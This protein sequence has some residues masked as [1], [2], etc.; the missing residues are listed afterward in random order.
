[1]SPLGIAVDGTGNLFVSDSINNRV[2]KITASN[3]VIT[4]V[5][6]TGTAGSG[7]DNGPAAAAQL[8]QPA[9]LAVDAAGNL[10]IADTGNS[11][12]RKVTASGIIT[13]IAGNGSPGFGGDG[14]PAVAAPLS[15]PMGV[16]IDSAGNL[17][18]ADS[19]NHPVC[20][21]NPS[22]L[23]STVAGSGSSAFPGGFG[24]DGGPA[25]SAQLSL[26]GGVSVDTVGNLYI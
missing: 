18:V 5:A 16:A 22:G 15:N 23:I 1:M 20:K 10:F 6:G 11:R 12:I 14:G 17:F 21:I 19:F 24:G 3:G 7:G 26:P 13:T 9:G 2:R 4:T 8:N 25:T